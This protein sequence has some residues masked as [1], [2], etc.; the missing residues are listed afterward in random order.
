MSVVFRF[1]SQHLLLC[2]LQN[3]F[4]LQANFWHP[5]STVSGEV[6]GINIAKL[7][8]TRTPLSMLV[9]DSQPQLL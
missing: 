1:A 8:S 4:L 2:L 6:G 9:P 3:T 5:R 7:R